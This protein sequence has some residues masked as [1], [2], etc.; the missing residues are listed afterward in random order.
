MGKKIIA[1]VCSALFFASA[2]MAAEEI[3]V[4]IVQHNDAAD[5][6]C[7]SSMM[8]ED[9]LLEAF[10]NQG[11]IVSSSPSVESVSEKQDSVLLKK[12]LTEADDGG[13]SY[14]VQVKIYYR[15]VKTE[16]PDETVQSDIDY[17]NW[18]LYNG[19]SGKVIAEQ[20]KS[21]GKN[22]LRG[23]DEDSVRAFAASIAADIQNSLKIQK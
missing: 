1:A 14:F 3:S 15:T 5:A 18:T 2:A 8:V 10:F 11:F 19:G 21:I 20:K 13:L 4:Q 23:N 6:I 12:A 22:P 7:D 17:V 16:N 9:E